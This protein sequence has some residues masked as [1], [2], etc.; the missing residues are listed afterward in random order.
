MTWQTVAGITAAVAALGAWVVSRIRARTAR[1]VALRG[2]EAAV[3]AHGAAHAA[4]ARNRAQRAEDATHD[5]RATHTARALAD[6]LRES[7][8]APASDDGVRAGRR[9]RSKF[10]G[11]LGLD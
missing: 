1:R 7:P 9:P 11:E 5:A 3:G 2:R 8:A 6:A 10:A 4:A